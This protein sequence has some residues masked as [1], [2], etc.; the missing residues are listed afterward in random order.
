MWGPLSSAFPRVSPGRVISGHYIPKET[1]VSTSSH[2]T[3]H[4]PQVFPE[5][6]RYNPDRWLNA[7]K[8]M[9]EMS[10]PF[11]YGP[12]NCIGKHLAQIGL[13]LTLSR[14]YQLYDIENDGCMTSDMMRLKDRGV[15][16][17]WGAKV[18]IKPTAVHTT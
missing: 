16:A 13:F 14:L 18:V 3:S 15:S 7:D 6:D 11:S 4:D 9:K 2:A 1:I 12:R 17:P 10:R 5:P 8:E